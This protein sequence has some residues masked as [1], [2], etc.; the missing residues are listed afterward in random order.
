MA[1]DPSTTDER[2]QGQGPPAGP[3]GQMEVASGRFWTPS[4]AWSQEAPF[5][6]LKVRPACLA[7]LSKDQRQKLL[8]VRESI[9]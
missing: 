1:E 9:T 7:G 4:P 6:G 5:L 2:E 8:C 3:P